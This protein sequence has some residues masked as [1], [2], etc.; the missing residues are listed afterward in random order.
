MSSYAERIEQC[1][2]ADAGAVRLANATTGADDTNVPDAIASLI[3]GYGGGGGGE[4]EYGQFVGGFS[5]GSAGYKL[6]IT[7]KKKPKMC[8]IW[9]PEDE[10]LNIDDSQK[11]NNYYTFAAFID[12]EAFDL[13]PIYYNTSQASQDRPYFLY[14]TN[15]GQ[16]TDG[17]FPNGIQIVNNRSYDKFALSDDGIIIGKFSS[18]T[19]YFYAATYHYMLV[20]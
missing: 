17:K 14:I 20:Y 8:M 18:A 15:F 11:L 2:L 9:L 10:F 12:N 13:I 3:A 7:V 16:A 6:P 1:A 5:I 19:S 4:V